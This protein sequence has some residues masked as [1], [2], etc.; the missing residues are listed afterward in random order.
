MVLRMSHD[1][2]IVSIET[3]KK[4]GHLSD[5]DKIVLAYHLIEE[6]KEKDALKLLGSI[7]QSY[8][9]TYIHKDVSRALLCYLIF[10]TTQQENLRKESEFYLVLYKLTKHIL[11]NNLVFNK[12]GFFYTLKDE[13]FKDFEL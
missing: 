10:K 11:R 2:N 7:N 8:Y 9:L 3:R 4:R 6:S 13:L 1:N 12:S 5:K